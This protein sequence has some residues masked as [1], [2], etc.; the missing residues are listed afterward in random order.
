MTPAGPHRIA[1]ALY[2][3]RHAT[4]AFVYRD[5]TGRY[6][7]TAVDLIE[8]RLQDDRKIEYVYRDGELIKEPK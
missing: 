4:T 8:T 7:W 6:D 1:A 3:K 2:S 5:P